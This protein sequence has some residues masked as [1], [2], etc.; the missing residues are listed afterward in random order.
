MLQYYLAGP[1]EAGQALETHLSLSG[2]T[3]FGALTKTTESQKCL[4]KLFNN[5]IKV[6]VMCCD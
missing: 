6:V 4:H 1:Q 5:H 2:S 3:R